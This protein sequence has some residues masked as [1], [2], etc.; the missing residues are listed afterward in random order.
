MAKKT[1]TTRK[2]VV[3]LTN[4]WINYKCS[5]NSN[6]K[7]SNG[8]YSCYCQEGFGEKIIDN[9]KVCDIDE[10]EVG[11]H[12]CSTELLCE[13]TLGSFELSVFELAS[14]TDSSSIVSTISFDQ[15]G[16]VLYHPKSHTQAPILQST[17]FP[18]QRLTLLPINV[19]VHKRL[20]VFY[21]IRFRTRGYREQY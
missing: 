5:Q 12:N 11:T 15:S 1:L 6:C 7:N 13:N 10:C 14:N 3:I 20:R 2:Y 19:S 17:I 16:L 8:S 9:K 21:R 4:V 18:G